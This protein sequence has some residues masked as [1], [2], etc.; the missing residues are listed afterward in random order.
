M[1]T[2]S[3][4]Y[5]KILGVEKDA[6]PDDLKKAYR[7]LAL[8]YHPDKCKEE[9]GEEIFKKVNEAYAVLSDPTRRKSY[10]L[11]GSADGPS[12]GHAGCAAGSHPM[13]GGFSFRTTGSGGGPSF[14]GADFN[15]QDFFSEMFA[16]GLFGSMGGS[17][18][19]TSGT[20]FGG[21]SA[22]SASRTFGAGP[23]VRPIPARA[24]RHGSRRTKGPTVTH[25]LK[26]S[27]GDL[28]RSATKKLKITRQ[29]I[30]V[31]A[32]PYQESHQVE[33]GLKPW[34]KS[35]TK[36]TFEGE[37]DQTKLQEPGDISFV[38]EVEQERGW[39]R[40]GDDLILTFPLDLDRIMEEGS[41]EIT[42]LSGQ[43]FE[44]PLRF[45]LDPSVPHRIFGQGMPTKDG[46]RGDLKVNLF[47]I[48]P[49]LSEDQKRDISKI[50]K[51]KE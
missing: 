18:G 37:G 42:H 4:D 51:P 28:Y 11:W 33:I 50:L 31:S 38:L 40:E 5:Y 20:S 22:P 15:P 6:S 32:L 47:P 36:A 49:Y 44:V 34:Y 46:R 3:S 1:A 10:D 8:K 19:S 21:F 12:F 2:S 25:T 35:G 23:R 27:L 41:I 17:M 39:S 26:V 30:G 43:H 7:K 48:I 14:V 45:P 9:G 29:R 16:N 13:G 24:T